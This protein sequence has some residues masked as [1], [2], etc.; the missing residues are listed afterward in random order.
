M[1]ENENY[2]SLATFR[3]DGRAV[4]TPIW[5]APEG[6]KLYPLAKEKE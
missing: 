4:E 2:L 5:F 1:L 6:V 3:R